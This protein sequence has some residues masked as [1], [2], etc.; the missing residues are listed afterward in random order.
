MTFL[1]NLVWLG[2]ENGLKIYETDS[3]R[4]KLTVIID[5]PEYLQRAEITAMASDNQDVWVGT[6]EGLFQYRSATGNWNTH[7]IL[8]G[9]PGNDISAIIAGDKFVWV[10]TAEEGLSRYNK[11]TGKWDNFNLDDG[12]ADNNIRSIAL[13]GKYVWIGTFS[14]GVCRYDTTTELWTTYRT[15]GNLVNGIR[16]WDFGFRNANF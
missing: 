5:I 3:R 9:L 10:G 13:D 15:N 2:R 4:I 6:R 12:L 11:A 16:N 14:G 1:D 8:N 7:T